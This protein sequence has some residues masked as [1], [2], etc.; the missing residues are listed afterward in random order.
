M[1]PCNCLF[2]NI[3]N[4][5]I[6]IYTNITSI[7]FKYTKYLCPIISLFS[8][9]TKYFALNILPQLTSDQLSLFSSCLCALSNPKY[10]ARVT[11]LKIQMDKE[12]SAILSLKNE[13][14]QGKTIMIPRRTNPKTRCFNC[15]FSNG[16]GGARRGTKGASNVNPH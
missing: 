3:R 13:N 5:I 16:L 9:K 1:S 2:N 14:R 4:L 7:C 10:I 8:L 6:Y 11:L 12:E 15:I